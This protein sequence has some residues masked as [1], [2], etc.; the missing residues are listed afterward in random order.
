MWHCNIQQ[1]KPTMTSSTIYVIAFLGAIF[2][3]LVFIAA[4]ILWIIVADHLYTMMDLETQRE[5]LKQEKLKK[6]IKN[7]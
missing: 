4:S 5:R 3:T 2:G 1:E 6:E 7:L